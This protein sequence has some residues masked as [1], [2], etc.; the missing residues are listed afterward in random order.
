MAIIKYSSKKTIIPN[1]LTNELDYIKLTVKPF[2]WGEKEK[3]TY[4]LI[5]KTNI[6]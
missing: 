3:N 1:I 4:T 5:N 2:L 6:R